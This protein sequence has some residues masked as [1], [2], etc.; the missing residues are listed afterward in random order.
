MENSFFEIKN[1]SFS[2]Y[3]QPFCFRNINLSFNNN[4]K[5]LLLASKDMVKTTFLSVISSFE[6]SYYGEILLNGKELNSIDDKDKNFSY[7]PSNPVFIEKKSIKY[8][9]DFF[10]KNNNLEIISNDALNKIFN[11]K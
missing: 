3:K 2:Y 5:V 11:D 6:N 9:F 4:E 1:L 7:L 8:N 10:L